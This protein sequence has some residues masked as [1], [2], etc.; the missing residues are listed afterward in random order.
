MTGATEDENLLGHTHS[1]GDKP[2][3]GSV[4][5]SQSCTVREQ[6]PIVVEIGGFVIGPHHLV[7]LT[8]HPGAGSYR[9]ILRPD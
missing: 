4:R 1:R 9:F 2:A 5:I 8:H 7:T 6:L 3:D